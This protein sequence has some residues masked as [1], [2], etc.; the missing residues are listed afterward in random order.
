MCDGNMTC[1]NGIIVIITPECEVVGSDGD[2]QLFMVG[3]LG[4]AGV[5]EAGIVGEF[6]VIRCSS[7]FSYPILCVQANYFGRAAGCGPDDELVVG[8]PIEAGYAIVG[9]DGYLLGNSRASLL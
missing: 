6:V 3:R 8:S 5:A 1:S 4:G 7:F 9:A 2:G